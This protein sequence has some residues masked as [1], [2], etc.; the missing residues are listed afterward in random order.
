MQ[1]LVLPIRKPEAP[2]FDNCYL[3]EPNRWVGASLRDESLGMTWLSG[4]NSSGKTH[5]ALA[6]NSYWQQQGYSSCYFDLAD[7][8]AYNPEDVLQNIEQH[9]YLFLDNSDYVAG[10]LDWEHALFSL[11]NTALERNNSI[12]FCANSNPVVSRFILPDLVSRF[13]SCLSLRLQA[14][15]DIDKRHILKSRALRSGLRL[16][17]RVIDYLLTHSSRDLKVLIGVLS[18]LDQTSWRYSRRVT[19][20]MVKD[21]LELGRVG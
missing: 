17:N 13:Q 10:V 19:V 3:G 21:V 20:A 16:N 11:Y 14:P 18:Q 8:A 9:N 15:S 12:V 6:S 2:S 4:G 1:Q 5:L 7:L